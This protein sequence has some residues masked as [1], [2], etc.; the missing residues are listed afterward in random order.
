M[1]VF[2]AGQVQQ[3]LPTPSYEVFHKPKRKHRV[4]ESVNKTEKTG[5][6]LKKD[7]KIDITA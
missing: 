7:K 4:V 2:A 6:K 5:L 1:K 3:M